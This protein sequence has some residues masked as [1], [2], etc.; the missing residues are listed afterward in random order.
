ME[1]VGEAGEVDS[2]ATVPEPE[3]SC[4][5]AEASGLEVVVDVAAFKVA[6]PA[7]P[8]GVLLDGSMEDID[9]VIRAVFE[10]ERATEEDFESE[11]EFGPPFTPVGEGFVVVEVRGGIFCANPKIELA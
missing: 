2:A 1:D 3:V 5:E 10:L 4:R 6:V 7:D 11:R 9:P 8:V